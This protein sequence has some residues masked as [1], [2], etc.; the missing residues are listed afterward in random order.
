VRDSANEL[1][2]LN[3]RFPAGER[4]LCPASMDSNGSLCKALHSDPYA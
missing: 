4:R 3:G 2:D 1:M